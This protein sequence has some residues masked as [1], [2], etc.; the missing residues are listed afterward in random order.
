[1]SSSAG[2][3]IDESIPLSITACIVVG[4]VNPVVNAS[5]PLIIYP[6]DI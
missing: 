6:V 4:T 2:I 5:H 3:G 1:M